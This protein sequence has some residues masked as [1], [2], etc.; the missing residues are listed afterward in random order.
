[1]ARFVELSPGDRIGLIAFAGSSV[2]LSP[3]TAD[4]SAL[5]MFIES[6]S[7]ESISTQGTSFRSALETAQQ[8]LNRGGVEVGED[9]IVTR[10]L[11]IASDGEDHEEG[12]VELA[13]A[14]AKE[15][16]RIFTL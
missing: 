10:A 3:L 1:L 6:L 9:G 12:A 4:K 8:A 13:N 7:T 14:L 11:L 5:I 2:L 16:L 15:G